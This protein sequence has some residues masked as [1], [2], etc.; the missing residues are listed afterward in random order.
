MIYFDEDEMVNRLMNNREKSINDLMNEMIDESINIF[1]REFSTPKQEAGVFKREWIN[2]CQYIADI[3]P[4]DVRVLYMTNGQFS[5]DMLRIDWR[6]INPKVIRSLI[7]AEVPLQQMYDH[8]I[9]CIS[10]YS[11]YYLDAT[12]ESVLRMH[13]ALNGQHLVRVKATKDQRDFRQR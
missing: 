1:K 13:L 5:V 7:R 9:G 8:T 10:K 4:D 3:Y 12:Y 2:K 6:S 11:D